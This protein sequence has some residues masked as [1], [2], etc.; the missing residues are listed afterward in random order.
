MRSALPAIFIQ[1]ILAHG[2]ILIPMTYV[3][4]YGNSFKNR[5]VVL[6]NTLPRDIRKAQG[7]GEF[8]WCWKHYLING[9]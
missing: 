5:G 8:K 3:E 6:R 4:Q 7:I 1:S 9:D 2:K